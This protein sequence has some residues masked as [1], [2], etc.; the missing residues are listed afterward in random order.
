MER[1]GR[2]PGNGWGI[3]KES[4]RHPACAR[5]PRPRLRGGNFVVGANAALV[6]SL[7]AIAAASTLKITIENR[8][9]FDQAIAAVTASR[10]GQAHGK[11]VI[12]I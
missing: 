2:F 4:R 8:V 11:T 9:P 3:N 6:E 5:S 12:M 1:L 7:G 10:T